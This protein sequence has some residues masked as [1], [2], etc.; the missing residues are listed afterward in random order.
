MNEIYEAYRTAILTGF[1]FMHAEAGDVY[2]LLGGIAA[3]SLVLGFIISPKEVS[4]QQPIVWGIMAIGLAIFIDLIPVF[5]EDFAQGMWEVGSSATGGAR[6]EDFTDFDGLMMSGYELA[7]PIIAGLHGWS[8]WELAT[9]LEDWFWGWIALSILILINAY[10][11]FRLFILMLSYLTMT[12]VAMIALPAMIWNRTS[13]L[14]EGALRFIAGTGISILGF[15]IVLSVVWGV[16]DTLEFTADMLKS[17]ILMNVAK[18]SVGFFLAIRTQTMIQG[19]FAGSPNVS[20][21]IGSAI[22]SGMFAMGA[23]KSL[24]YAARHVA[25]N[26]HQGSGSPAPSMGSPSTNPNINSTSGGGNR[27]G[28]GGQWRQ[29]NRRVAGRP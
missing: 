29:P 26:Q 15:G 7:K 16:A 20:S 11:A 21:G 8:W 10:L 2:L 14:A 5:A 23:M 3:F 12:L 25:N 1:G 18:A 22:R 24:M 19:Y 13:F 27:G 4:V 6:V 17:E 9:R 28:F